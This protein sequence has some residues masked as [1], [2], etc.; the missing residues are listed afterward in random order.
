MQ[1]IVKE[2]LKNCDPIEDLDSEQQEALDTDVF[3]LRCA[4]IGIGSAGID[5]VAT[6]DDET[7]IAIGT[8]TALDAVDGV[9]D[10]RITVAETDSAEFVTDLQNT[11]ADIDLAA[12]TAHLDDGYT[13]RLVRTVNSCLPDETVSLVVPTIPEDGLPDTA[14]DEFMDIISESSSIVP[15][16]L[17]Q[18]ADSFDDRASTPTEVRQLTDQLLVDWIQD[19]IIAARDPLIVPHLGPE[20]PYQFLKTAGT[21]VLYWGRISQDPTPEALVSDAASHSLCAGNVQS[22]TG[23]FGFIRLGNSF[24]NSDFDRTRHKIKNAFHPQSA[25]DPDWI[26]CA[27]AE[28]NLGEKTEEL[29]EECRLEVML[30]GIDPHSLGFI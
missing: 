21:S 19:I 12:V 9:V 15:F 27:D 17:G 18:I 29:G 23:G 30:C 5:R 25:D 13:A 4:V 14:S 8:D 24:T 28:G 11:L 10:E 6:V 26:I 2:A 16:D 1:D 3:V 20:I 22:A 7:T